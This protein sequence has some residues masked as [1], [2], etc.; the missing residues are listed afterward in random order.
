MADRPLPPILGRIQATK[1]EEIA[2]LLARTSEQALFERAREASRTDPPRDFFRAIATG[3][4]VRIIAEIKH[5]SPSKG[6]LRKDFDPTALAAAYTRGGA[7]ALSCLTDETYFQ[8]SL[9]DL[10]QARAASALPVLR[11]DFL[12]HPAQ[13]AEARAAGADAVLC[14][15]RMLARKDLEALLQAAVALGLTPLTEIHDEADLEVALA[16]QAPLI[17]VNNRDLD[18]FVVDVQTTYRLRARIPETVPVVAESGITSAQDLRRLAEA[19]VAAALVGESLLVQT[20]VET[21]VRRLRT[22][23]R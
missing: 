18:T 1:Q 9:N 10:R 21:A 15:A 17:G 12:L 4:D 13:V 19:G 22:G 7:A 8:G 20:D 5:T 11:K 3:P 6:L 16:A 14:I 2:R 23:A